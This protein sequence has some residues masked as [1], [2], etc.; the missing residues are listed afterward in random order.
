MSL[1]KRIADS[2][3]VNRAVEGFFAAYLRFAVRTSRWERHGFDAMDD[4]LRSGEPVIFTLWHQRLIMAPYMFDTSLGKFCSLT[5]SARAGRM[6][7]QVLARFGFDTVPM[8]S[9]KRHVALSR[10]VLRRVGDGFT[11][12]IAVDGPRGPARVASTVPLVWARSTGKPVF[13]LS[14]SARRVIRLPTWDR[15]MLP[16]P[17]T[18]GVLIC[19]RW[20]MDVP[21]KMDAS[22][23]ENLRLDLEAALDVVTDESDAQTGQG[24]RAK[25]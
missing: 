13:V 16:L 4:V 18:R 23:V 14:F 17:F 21:R 6:V 3:R 24:R 25:R 1:R 19:A 9:H 11:L 7:G 8:S 2:P 5:S 15:A 22:E 20:D 10:E 12:G